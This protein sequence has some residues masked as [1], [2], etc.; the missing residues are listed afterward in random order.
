[1]NLTDFNT[2]RLLQAKAHALIP[3]G[4]H[5]YAKG[6]DQFPEEA[7][8]FIR[9]GAGC[10]VWDVDGNEFIE[11]GM[12]LRSVTLGHAY[13]PVL[14]AA[15]RE[16]VMGQ[17][18]N[19]PSPIEVECAEALLSMVPGGEM[20][21]FAKDGSTVT[22]AALTLARAY[23][24]RDMV[25]LCSDHPF[26]SYNDWF[27]G[28]T[29]VSSGIPEAIKALTATF[30]YNDIA[31]LEDVF[32]AHP[33]RIACVIL[34]AARVEEP[35]DGFLHKV[36]ALCR[37]NGALFI[38]DEMIT[39]FRWANGGAQEVYGITPDLSAFGKAMANGFSLSALVGRR[40]IMELGGLT[41]SRPRV[42]LLSTTHGAETHAMAAAIATMEVYRS[43]DV[44]SHLHRAGERLRQ[45]IEQAITAHGVAGKFS[46]AGPPCN[47]LYSTLDAEGRPSQDFRTL[48]LQ[49]TIRKG[50]L[51]PSFIVS[52]SHSDEDIDRSIEAVDAA[53]AVYRRA[54]DDGIEHYLR[55]RPVKPVYR[56]FN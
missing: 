56:K 44:I 32:A 42:F 13:K 12:G 37:R 16:M 2:S 28:T 5:T 31:S 19:R 14:D 4:S 17:N 29:A 48:F 20:V 27:I 25:A 7:P 21:K 8:G 39:G 34:E 55:G 52:Y 35:K 22:T 46:I 26:F 30:R 45:G 11:Y 40:E 53:L 33:G 24:G 6:D 41:S 43:E 47:L 3:G 54:L 23:T 9:R 15:M 38:L 1:M 49:E 10:H 50:L 36:Q 51:A 18:F